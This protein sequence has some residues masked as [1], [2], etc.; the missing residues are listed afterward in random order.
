MTTEDLVGAHDMPTVN[1]GLITTLTEVERPVVAL[2]ETPGA[3]EVDSAT[4]QE[5]HTR[6][7]ES[8]TPRSKEMSLVANLTAARIG[9]GA[10]TA[11][12]ATTLIAFFMQWFTL[13][14]SAFG[15]TPIAV[16]LS[17]WNY[18]LRAQAPLFGVG[19]LLLPAA[20]ASLWGVVGGLLVMI[21]PRVTLLRPAMIFLLASYGMIGL[22]VTL[23]QAIALPG[24]TIAPDYAILP[25]AWVATAG[26]I[27]TTVSALA[28]LL[29]G[30]QRLRYR[31]PNWA[32]IGTLILALLWPLTLA[33][34]AVLFLHS[35]ASHRITIGLG[36]IVF[37]EAFGA[38]ALGF[39][40][41]RHDGPVPGRFAAL[42][43]A[44]AWLHLLLPLALLGG[45]IAVEVLNR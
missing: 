6:G 28:W 40:G 22:S 35:H 34:L 9:G 20:L 39:R 12:G 19:I 5:E 26:A 1:A 15:A 44:M 24:I 36:A 30:G 16:T 13:T 2:P 21:R 43:L 14:F 18:L 11:S 23:F 33:G 42:S 31:S 8:D 3:E 4:D 25:G 10:C 38:I 7:T 45:A 37:L 29:F 17:G 32:A 41:S 27:V